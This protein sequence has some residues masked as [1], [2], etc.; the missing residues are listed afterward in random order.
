MAAR[1]R[2]D[3]AEGRRPPGRANEKGVVDLAGDAMTEI[4]T[5]V[6]TELQRCARRFPKNSPSRHY[7]PR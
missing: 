1:S 2:S 7:P 4:A 3:D 6:Q 5:L